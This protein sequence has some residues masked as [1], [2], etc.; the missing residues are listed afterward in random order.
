MQQEGVRQLQT[1][2]HNFTHARVDFDSS[3]PTQL[4]P[5]TSSFFHSVLS[6]IGDYGISQSSDVQ[7]CTPRTAIR[8]AH[9]SSTL[10]G[11]AAL[12]DMMSSIRTREPRRGRN[13]TERLRCRIR[14]ARMTFHPQPTPMGLKWNRSIRADH[15]GKAGKKKQKRPSTCLN[16]V[17][18]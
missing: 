7:T 10:A 11:V 4:R 1:V 12:L 14:R 5:I 3:F 8:K 9:A 18:R 17:I 6:Q 13:A 16:M 2:A 15:A